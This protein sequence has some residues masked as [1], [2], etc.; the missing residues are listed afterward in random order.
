MPMSSMTPSRRPRRRRPG[1]SRFSQAQV[2]GARGAPIIRPRLLQR[3]TRASVAC[4]MSLAGVG[5]RRRSCSHGDALNVGGTWRNAIRRQVEERGAVSNIPPK[6]NRKPGH[7]LNGNPGSNLGGNRQNSALHGP[8][9]IFHAT[10]E[11]RPAA[12]NRFGKNS[13]SVTNHQST[14]ARMPAA[15]ESRTTM[16]GGVRHAMS[17]TKPIAAMAKSAGVKTALV[18]TGL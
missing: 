5:R 1:G 10:I 8:S 14:A 3:A 15:A 12:R 11:V 9:T 4:A 6:A 16:S 13:R 2:G 17:R 7:V 18:H